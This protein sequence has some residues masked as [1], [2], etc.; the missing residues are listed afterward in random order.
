MMDNDDDEELNLYDGSP[1]E[2]WLSNFF[3]SNNNE[4]DLDNVE[5]NTHD[6][7]PDNNSTTANDLEMNTDAIHVVSQSQL[8][9]GGRLK[10]DNSTPSSQDQRKKQKVVME[11]TE[12]DGDMILQQAIA[13]SLVEDNSMEDTED[14]D[15]IKQA[16]ENSLK[17]SSMPSDGVKPEGDDR[18]SES[19]SCCAGTGPCI[20]RNNTTTHYSSRSDGSQKYDLSSMS[21]TLHGFDFE[22][23][24]IG[25][26][27]PNS[28]TAVIFPCARV[29]I[30]NDAYDNEQSQVLKE[31]HGAKQIADHCNMNLSIVN[32]QYDAIGVK[33]HVGYASSDAFRQLKDDII[34]LQKQGLLNNVDYIWVMFNDILRIGLKPSHLDDLLKELNELGITNVQVQTVRQF[35]QGT[36]HLRKSAA[37]NEKLDTALLNI[38]EKSSHRNA[39]KEL[40]R[41][42]KNERKQEEI[43]KYMRE[44]EKNFNEE[45]TELNNLINNAHDRTNLLPQVGP[46]YIQFLDDLF[47]DMDNGVTSPKDGVKLFLEYIDENFKDEKE[48]GKIFHLGYTV[49]SHQ[50]D[51][52]KKKKT[53]NGEDSVFQCSY[54]LG[55]YKATGI[56][57]SNDGGNFILLRSNQRRRR[58]VLPPEEMALGL[59]A[60][61][62]ELVIDHTMTTSTRVS[63]FLWMNE[64]VNCLHEETD[65]RLYLAQHFGVTNDPTSNRDPTCYQTFKDASIAESQRVADEMKAYNL[66]KKERQAL[67][68][69]LQSGTIISRIKDSK[70][71]REFQDELEVISKKPITN[72]FREGLNKAIG[73]NLFMTNLVTSERSIPIERRRNPHRISHRR[74]MNDNDDDMDMDELT[75]ATTKVTLT[76][77]DAG[78]TIT[79]P[80]DCDVILHQ[81]KSFLSNQ[82]NQVL[83]RLIKENKAE[84]DRVTKTEKMNIRKDIIADVMNEI[85]GVTFWNKKNN[86]TWNHLES[87][88]DI[89]DRI[90]RLMNVLRMDEN[91]ELVWKK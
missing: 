55:F 3:G 51:A 69:N 31:I 41:S 59:L 28:P 78:D 19:C 46:E 5:M 87:D 12:D 21:S 11:D 83:Y 24:P 25:T 44:Y 1:D 4:D 65:T 70:E 60:V 14:A 29:S 71:K 89:G 27:K 22:L 49:C 76:T 39:V 13:N 42:S 79:E 73:A 88:R 85:E 86:K 26:D 32:Y 61:G 47:E 20:N 80:R 75:K 15:M 50:M 66:A 64:F 17:D 90:K 63:S 6:V 53:A 77:L 38:H 67:K 33:R 16:I 45:D 40:P 37:I 72:K 68:E 84:Y 43:D 7:H 57:I 36:G 74:S 9:Q 58:G 56:I 10:D 48:R 8:S 18:P 34:Q 23:I 52:T 2:R 30:D 62:C 54:I 82:G 81:N 91:G 35:D